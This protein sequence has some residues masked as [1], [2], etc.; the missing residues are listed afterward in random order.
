M[1]RLC[2][3][4]K[5]L[6]YW[7]ANALVAAVAFHLSSAGIDVTL[8]TSCHK[9]VMTCRLPSPRKR[10]RFFAL[11]LLSSCS[12]KAFFKVRWAHAFQNLGSFSCS[13][14]CNKQIRLYLDSPRNHQMQVCWDFA[15]TLY[16]MPKVHWFQLLQLKYLEISLFFQGSQPNIF[17]YLSI[18]YLKQ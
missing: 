12:V 5:S 4:H 16:K 2:A 6:A 8:L 9:S 11:F 17:I 7:R 10:M 1:S 3:D 15:L 14:Y 13:V 18:H